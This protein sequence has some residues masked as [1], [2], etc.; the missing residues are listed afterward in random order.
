VRATTAASSPSSIS[1]GTS[2]VATSGTGDGP[3]SAA[4]DHALDPWAPVWPSPASTS[5]P[6]GRQAATTSA[7]PAA[8][9]AASGARS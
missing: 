8:Q 6:C 4:C 3:H 1:I 7:Q 9:S 2:R 5:A